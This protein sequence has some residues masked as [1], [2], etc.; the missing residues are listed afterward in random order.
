MTR[1]RQGVAHLCAG[2]DAD[3][4][5][6]RSIDFRS[7]DGAVVVGVFGNGD[8]GCQSGGGVT[9]LC[10]VTARW[11]GVARHVGQRCR[12]SQC[13]AVGRTGVFKVQ[14]AGCEVDGVQDHSRLTRHRQGV[15]HLCA[16]RDAD[17]HA[18]RSIDFRSADGAVVVGVFGDGDDRRQGGGGITHLCAVT[19]RWRGV[20]RHIGQRRRHGECR[21]VGRTGVFKVQGSGRD[22]CRGHDNRSLT[23]HGQGIT[24]FCAGRDT[25]VDA[26]RAT[27]LG[28]ADDA[29]V[30]GVFG[31]ADRGCQG[32]CGVTHACAVSASR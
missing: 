7:A 1:H 14:R 9:H 17:V 8:D 4:H 12:N 23:R 30:V 3:V 2:R 11:R 28:T 19:T 26:D 16:G 24:D 15:A 25:D 13:R 5:A 20:T 10:A 29:V 6:D 22:S 32:G 18:D 27:D 31:N 21:A